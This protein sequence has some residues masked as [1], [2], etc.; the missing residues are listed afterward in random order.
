VLRHWRGT[1]QPRS[2]HMDIHDMKRHARM[3]MMISWQAG[4]VPRSPWGEVYS[5]ASANHMHAPERCS[6]VNTAKT[7]A[8]VMGG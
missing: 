7:D 8:K 6:H 3:E 2:C 5:A 4:Q 1:R